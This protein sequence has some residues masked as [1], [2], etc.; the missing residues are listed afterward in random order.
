S[1]VA[2]RGLVVTGG[3]ALRRGAERLFREEAGLPVTLA[4][5]ALTCVARGGRRGLALIDSRGRGGLALVQDYSPSAHMAA[6]LLL[7]RVRCPWRP[8]INRSLA[9]APK[10]G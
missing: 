5:E 7:L 9:S 4:D 1:G 3:G 8:P 10:P 6:G 2:E